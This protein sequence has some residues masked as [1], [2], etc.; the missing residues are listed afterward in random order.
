MEYFN[1]SKITSLLSLTQVSA[2]TDS[3]INTFT[4]LNLVFHR[5]VILTAEYEKLTSKAKKQFSFDLVLK[6]FMNAFQGKFRSLS[7]EIFEGFITMI[8]DSLCED[9]QKLYLSNFDLNF[10]SKMA[11]MVS[12]KTT[13]SK[14][15]NLA[16]LESSMNRFLQ[17]C[18]TSQIIAATKRE[19]SEKHRLK[20]LLTTNTTPDRSLRRFSYKN[21]SERFSIVSSS[22][23]GI[24][25]YR[26]NR[27]GSLLHKSGKFIKIARKSDWVGTSMKVN[28]KT[29][30]QR[31]NDSLNKIEKS[32]NFF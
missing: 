22:L 5:M 9:T 2:Y 17:S 25:G 13:N 32:K 30:K 28:V 14:M 3:I 20:R 26:S 21:P 10:T 6:E 19:H 23:N 16:T 18:I 27:N 15:K 1:T 4:S 31:V 24:R 11:K 7:E 29:S 8:N 12:K